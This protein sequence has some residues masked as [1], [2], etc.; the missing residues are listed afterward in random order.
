MKINPIIPQIFPAVKKPLFFS[1]SGEFF[2]TFEANTKAK[3]EQ[4][5][6]KKILEENKIEQMPN[7]IEAIANPSGL[8]FDAV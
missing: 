1:F 2:V 7:T 8:D 5:S 3:I 4:A 6:P